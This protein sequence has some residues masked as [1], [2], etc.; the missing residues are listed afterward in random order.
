MCSKSELKMVKLKTNRWK[1]ELCIH[2][3][4]SLIIRNYDPW[5]V[6][7]V[8][9]VYLYTILFI[10][11]SYGLLQILLIICYI[12]G[13]GKKSTPFAKYLGT[14]FATLKYHAF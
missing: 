9:P 5:E 1:I 8:A 13:K 10:Y 12:I 6:L 3:I 2:T 7:F 11:Y 14:K 4:P